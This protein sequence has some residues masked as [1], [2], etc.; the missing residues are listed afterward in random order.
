MHLGY[1]F[2]SQKP[3]TGKKTTFKEIMR[4]PW[5]SLK[6]GPSSTVHWPSYLCFGQRSFLE[7]LLVIQFNNF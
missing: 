1:Y 5:W 6:T 3:K 7:K 4:Q 2:K